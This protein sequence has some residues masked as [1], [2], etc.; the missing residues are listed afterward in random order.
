M[1]CFF[2]TWAS[3]ST[4]QLPITQIHFIIGCKCHW[5]VFF[6]FFWLCSLLSL[7]HPTPRKANIRSILG[8]YG[9][10]TSWLLRLLQAVSK[11]WPAWICLFHILTLT[12]QC[13]SALV[14]HKTPSPSQ[15]TN[16]LPMTKSFQHRLLSQNRPSTP[17]CWFPRGPGHQPFYWVVWKVL[18]SPP[19]CFSNFCSRNLGKPKES[20]E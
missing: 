15:K 17:T 1:L 3:H 4:Y 8:R 16:S 7:Q 11:S 19:H 5:V 2:Y 9:Q 10:M 13:L 18:T 14:L 20:Y 12:A 6:F